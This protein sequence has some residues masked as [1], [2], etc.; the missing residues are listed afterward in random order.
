MKT[1]LLAAL[2]SAPMA[3]SAQICNY[4][5]PIQA[6]SQ[7]VGS[8]HITSD[9]TMPYNDGS[10]FYVCAGVHL[11]MEGSAGSNYYL[12][13][14]A[15]LTL[16]DHE[17]DNVIAKGNC[18]IVDQ[19]S[20][21]L[22]VTSEATTTV[23]KPNDPFNYVQLTC[24]NMTY[25]YQLFG[26]SSPCSLHLVE[27]ENK[28]IE[29]FPNPVANGQTV[30]FNEVVSSATIT[31]LSGRLVQEHFNLNSDTLPISDLETGI[32]LVAV[33]LENGTIATTRMQIH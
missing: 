2:F 8:F 6:V 30:Q 31:D 20:E 18:T 29:A 19:S 10:S 1:L 26:G 13:D 7:G 17:G 9:V 25:D 33:R 24:A 12:E 14:G 16:L 28:T 11:T 32:F 5:I 21:T 27:Q 22:V 23:S 4:T 3:L 15:M